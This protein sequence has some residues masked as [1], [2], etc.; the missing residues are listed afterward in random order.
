MTA[1]K[2][3]LGRG[4]GALLNTQPPTEEVVSQDSPSRIKTAEI[5]TIEINSIVVNPWQPR[6]EFEETSLNELAD[7]IKVHGLIQPITVRSIEENKYQLISGE[8]RVRAAKIA[9]ITDIPAYIRTADDL[10]VIEMALVENIQRENLNSMEIALSYQ[11]LIDE[12]NI[13]QEQVS[14]RVGKNRSTI[15]NYLRL[16]KLPSPV[17]ISVRDNKIS[18]GHARSILGIDDEELQVSICKDIT[19]KDLSVRQ[20]ED[21]VRKYNQ[22]NELPKK[23]LVLSLPERFE[24]AKSKLTNSLQSN[25]EIKRNIKGK[26]AITIQFKSDEDFERIISMLN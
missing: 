25:I 21:L 13:T 22:S 26:G 4:L 12:C 2:K 24:I 11:R 8:R 7:S 3:A 18:M 23:D 9:G 20:V 16:L 17:Q 10:Q 1:Q 6:T 14:L 5:S 15:T 19:N